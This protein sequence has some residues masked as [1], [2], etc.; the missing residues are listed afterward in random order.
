MGVKYVLSSIITH[1]SFFN[2]GT[3]G[4]A[5]CTD[6]LSYFGFIFNKN[7]RFQYRFLWFTFTCIEKYQFELCSKYDKENDLDAILGYV[8]HCRKPRWICRKHSNDVARQVETP[9]KSTIFVVRHD[10]YVA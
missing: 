5:I 6:L 8:V 10:F 3:I 7:G 1:M 4:C 2:I 9:S